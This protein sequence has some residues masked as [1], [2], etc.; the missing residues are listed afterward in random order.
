M[1]KL[2]ARWWCSDCTATGGPSPDLDAIDR[3]AAAHTRTTNHT[4]TTSTTEDKPTCHNP[5][6]CRS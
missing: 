5:N 1:I 4:T 6:Q 3:A 2:S